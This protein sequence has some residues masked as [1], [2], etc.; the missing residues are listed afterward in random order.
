[1]QLKLIGTCSTCLVFGLKRISFHIEEISDITD[2]LGEGGK[3]I[4]ELEKARRALE[5][6]RT[7]LQVS[8][9]PRCVYISPRQCLQYCPYGV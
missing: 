6:E 9:F 1:M 5:H 4:H 3:S 8:E 2:Q 7:E